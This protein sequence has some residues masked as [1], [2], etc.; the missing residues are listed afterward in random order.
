MKNNEL[1]PVGFKYNI[2]GINENEKKDGNLENKP[3]KD[4]KKKEEEEEEEEEDEQDIE[5]INKNIFD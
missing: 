5:N 1:N 2:S 4:D 3:N